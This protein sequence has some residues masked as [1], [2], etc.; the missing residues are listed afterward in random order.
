M[1]YGAW[2]LLL[3][4]L[5]VLRVSA[6]RWLLS[7][8]GV[9]VGFFLV[10]VL[11]NYVTIGWAAL[12]GSAV[13]IGLGLFMLQ[14]RHAP[15]VLLSAALPLAFLVVDHSALLLA[16]T[17]LAGFISLWWDVRHRWSL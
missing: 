17:V 2:G 7:V 12:V 14:G 5:G 13:A 15:L 11:L 10:P 9:G 16:I 4:L 3:A 1:V 6:I 8:P